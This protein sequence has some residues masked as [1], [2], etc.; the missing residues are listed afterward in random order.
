MMG[1]LNS[2]IQIGFAM[3]AIAN[4]YS[5]V[6]TMAKKLAELCKSMT[7]SL[8]SFMKKRMGLKIIHKLG[9][10]ETRM[11]ALKTV[12]I[13]FVRAFSCVLLCLA[14]KMKS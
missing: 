4:F 12:I 2:I 3:I 1:G 14:A 10:P 9:N 7:T 8:L 5:H 11:K 6:S 13:N